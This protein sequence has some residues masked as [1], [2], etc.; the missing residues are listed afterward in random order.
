[1]WR[2]VAFLMAGILLVSA[3]HAAEPDKKAIEAALSNAVPGMSIESLRVSPIAGVYEADLG[4]RVVYISG[5][6]KFLFA[7]D[8]YDL[9]ARVN[10]TEQTRQ[11][12]VVQLLQGMSE[13]NMIVMGPDRPKR[14]ITVFTDVDCPY[15]ARLHLEVPALTKQGVKV[16][17]LL[18]PRNGLESETYKR[19]VAVWCA[20][21]RVK[22]VGVAK[23]GGRLEMKSCANPVAEHYQLGQRLGVSGTPTIFVDDGQKI[24]GYVPAPRLLAILGIAGEAGAA[25]RR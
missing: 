16:R 11:K 10:L 22:A 4:S 7:G 2:S 8:L 1:M 21:D 25:A 5:D 9:D 6:G 15:C 23:A 18:F 12:G 19:S 20:T 13:K 17:Y 24:G 14:T 3:S